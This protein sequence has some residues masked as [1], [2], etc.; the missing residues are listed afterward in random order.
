MDQTSIDNKGTHV[1]MLKKEML[2]LHER[3]MELEKEVKG[4]QAR[5][6]HVFYETPASR[7][8]IKCHYAESTYY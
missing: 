3:I 8:C 2:I 7:N 6:K 4:I 5:C 1:L